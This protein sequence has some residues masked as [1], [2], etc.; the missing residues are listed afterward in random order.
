VHRY[1]NL[2]GGDCGM[3]ARIDRYQPNWSGLG[4]I[5]VNGPATDPWYSLVS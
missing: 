4:E 2:Y 3:F 1:C 5:I